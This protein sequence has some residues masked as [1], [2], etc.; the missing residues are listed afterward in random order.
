MPFNPTEILWVKNCEVCL[1][2]VFIMITRDGLISNLPVIR[3]M[4]DFEWNRC[5][6]IPDASPNIRPIPDPAMYNPVGWI[7]GPVG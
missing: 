7:S 2:E 4:P 1:H 3:H 6:G 5:G